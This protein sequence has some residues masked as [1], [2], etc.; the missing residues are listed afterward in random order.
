MARVKDMSG[1]RFGR[2]VVRSFAGIGEDHTALW[3]C[4]CDCG[5]ETV[6][7]GY[8]LRRGHTQSCGCFNGYA[9]SVRN[10]THGETK[11]RLYKCWQGMKSRC[12]YERN[13]AYDRYGGRGIQVCDEWRDDFEAF[14]D[15]ALKNGYSDEL[16]L[17]RIDT[18]GHY[19]PS[20]CRWA[21][22][23]EQNRNRR[24]NVIVEH[25]GEIQTEAEWAAKVGIS[26]SSMSKRLQ[27]WKVSDA[28]T[29]ASRGIKVEHNG[30]EK[31]LKEWAKIT[32]IP[33]NTLKTRY[34]RGLSP[35]EILSKERYIEFNGE[36]KTLTEWAETLRIQKSTLHRR[37][38]NGWTAERALTE[39]VRLQP[40][41]A[42]K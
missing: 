28:V 22:M 1:Q 41:T 42:P 34:F 32:G 8:S 10:S 7:R 35:K 27:R 9:A 40:R 21:T 33:Y 12:Y 2:L 11:T 20:N 15:W 3:N 25:D 30:E 29:Q 37:F 6:V 23:V 4:V 31:S 17:D 16:T 38:K 26:K 13:I 36:S 24:D 14:R 39:P 18:N 5:N 19:E